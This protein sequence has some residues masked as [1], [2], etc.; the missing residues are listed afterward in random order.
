MC[1]VFCCEVYRIVFAI[2]WIKWLRLKEIKWASRNQ[3]LAESGFTPSPTES[4]ALPTLPW[5]LFI[6][7]G[8][9]FSFSFFLF[10]FGEED[11]PWANISANLPL[12]CMWDAATAWLDEWCVG[13]CWDP[14]PQTLGHQSGAHELNHYTTGPAPSISRYS[15]D[16]L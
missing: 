13:P 8:S 1:Q 2:V 3:W 7:S 6:C 5:C 10:I 14:N 9:R 11:C 12:F 15:F 4:H 16:P